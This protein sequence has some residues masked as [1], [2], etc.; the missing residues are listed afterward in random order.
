MNDTVLKIA[1]AG[2][3]HDIGKFAQGCLELPPGFRENNEAIFQPTAHH[4][5]G[6]SHQHAMFTAAFIEQLAASLPTKLNDPKWGGGES[7]DTFQK[8]AACHHKPESAMQRIITEADCISSGLDRATFAKGDSIPFQEFKSTRLLPV[9]EE[10]EI[11]SPGKKRKFTTAADFS[12]RYPLAPLSSAA[13]FPATEREGKITKAEADAEYR[14]LF[15]A[16]IA[17]LRSLWHT[18]DSL[19]LWAEHF[20][21]LLQTYTSSIPAARVKNV[22]H[23][24]SLYDHCRT[25]AALA[26]AIYLYHADRDTMNSTAVSTEQEE[27]FLLVTGDFYGIQDFIFAG[28]GDTQRYRSK[29][30]RGRSFAVSLFSELAADMLYRRA[31]LTFLSVI[32]NAAGKFTVLMP[33]TEA[34]RVATRDVEAEVNQWLFDISL[35][36]SSMGFSS[37]PASPANFLRGGFHGLWQKHCDNMD[38]RKGAKIDLDRYGGVVPGYLESFRNDL[39][40]KLCPLCGKRPSHP[41]VEKDKAWLHGD[42]SACRVCRDHV[43]LGTSLVKGNRLAIWETG[44]PLP[45]RE[46]LTMPIFGK[47][48]VSFTSDEH[49]NPARQGKLLHLFTLSAQADGTLDNQTA[50]RLI[51]G[52]VPVYRPEDEH[53][54][55]LLAGR[56]SEEKKLELVDDIKEGRPKTFAHIASK[57]LNQNPDGKKHQGIV[58]IGVLMSDIDNLG[59]LF[60]YDLKEDRYTISRIATLSRQLNFFFTLYLPHL[61]ANTEEFRDVYTVFAGGDDLFLIGPWNRLADLA[62]HLR[63]RFAAYCCQNPDIHFSAGITVHKPHVPVERLAKDAEESLAAAKNA[64]RNSITAF[65]ATVKWNN[66]DCLL[67]C[68]TEIR[69]WLQEG[70]IHVGSFYRFN[71]FLAMREQEKRLSGLG[72]SLLDAMSCLKWRALFV[73]NIERNMNKELKGAER[74]AARCRLVAFVDWLNSFDAGVRIPLWDVL[75]N[76]RSL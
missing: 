28:G 29:L 72:A 62:A 34:S 15:D 20:D 74:N 12:C 53:D 23:D 10:I 61:L 67:D 26:S 31:D 69:A 21:S 42:T 54:D 16:F 76:Q 2:L 27:K 19:S 18:Q 43:M 8:L 22:V 64:G 33:N 73:Y 46:C 37:T 48:N 65:N 56:A 51:N 35:G 75:Y 3:L 6:Y 14:K 4:G 60:G 44:H 17:G 45:A 58:A 5:G 7:G 68:R 30:L 47:Y 11:I 57:A 59:A 66:F 63:Q 49:P 39:A 50:V 38:K 41:A 55:R 40:S 70:L 1:L 32:L 25:T 52:Y 71:E 36:Q 24:I 13:I 9:L